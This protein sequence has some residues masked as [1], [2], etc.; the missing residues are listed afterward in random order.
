VGIADDPADPKAV[1]AAA[2]QLLARRDYSSPELAGRLRER[3]LDPTTVA[4]VIEALKRER[5]VDDARY[6][7]HFVSYHA[8]RGHGP[9][10]IGRDLRQLKLDRELIERFLEEG[11]D[12]AARAREVRQKKF[13]R[14]LPDGYAGKAKQ[15]RFLQYRGFTGAQIRAALG[16]DVDIDD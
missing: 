5:L 4:T 3:G 13:G 8:A 2:L 12:W 9:V 1:R 10:R 14:D 16:T 7:E 15:A 11:Q 6:V